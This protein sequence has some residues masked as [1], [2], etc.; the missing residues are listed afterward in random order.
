MKNDRISG[1]KRIPKLIVNP[2]IAP[3]ENEITSGKLTKKKI[4]PG[5]GYLKKI[6]LR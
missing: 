2:R 5:F 4:Y 6:I 3:R 1:K